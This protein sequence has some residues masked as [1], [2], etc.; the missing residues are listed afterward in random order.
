MTNSEFHNRI[1]KSTKDS[2]NGKITDV[3][4][5]ISEIEVWS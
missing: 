3:E 2:K 5:L 1:E 4:Y